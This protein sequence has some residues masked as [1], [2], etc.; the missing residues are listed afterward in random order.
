M[1]ALDAFLP[2]I[3]VAI[4]LAVLLIFTFGTQ[5]NISRGNAVLRWLQESLPRLGQRTT[6][7]W[8][9]SSVV[10]LRLSEPSE[11]FRELTILA[12]MEPRDVPI[13]WA[14]SRARGRRDVLIFRGSLRRAPR[15]ELEVSDPASWMI[16]DEPDE[17][18]GWRAIGWPGDV[19]ALARGQP[20]PSV[21]GAARTA[22]G[23]L[24]AA[25]AGVWRVS[26]RQTV[27]HLEIHVRPPDVRA[28]GSA[29]LVEAVHGLARDLAQDLTPA[30]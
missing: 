5:R 6:L 20:D 13:L 27:P 22:W 18:A 23:R 19:R 14:F 4:L 12:V 26:V 25:S 16:A 17:E 8:L 30:S 3:L 10:E 28:I 11:P 7:R 15:V 29:P 9:G 21:I 2:G 24:A 1:P